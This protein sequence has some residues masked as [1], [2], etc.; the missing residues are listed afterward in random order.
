MC[1]FASCPAGAMS[2]PKNVIVCN[3]ECPI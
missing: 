3:R 1:G 2:C